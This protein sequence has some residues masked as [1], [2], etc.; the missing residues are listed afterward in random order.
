MPWGFGEGY[1][2][3]LRMTAFWISFV[4]CLKRTRSNSVPAKSK[5]LFE[6]ISLTLR[7]LQMDDR[8]L[9]IKWCRNMG[10]G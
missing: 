9:E 8:D 4:S 10:R 3:G 6:A 1:E 5:E 7:G 2:V